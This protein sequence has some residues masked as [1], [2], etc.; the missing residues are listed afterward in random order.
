MGPSSLE[1]QRLVS[2]W[3]ND[4][5]QANKLVRGDLAI[6][7]NTADP[8]K[9]TCPVLVLATLEMSLHPLSRPRPCSR[10]SRVAIARP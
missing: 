3:V 5:V 10:V 4:L 1:R 6:N 7:G 2:R 9:I 8:S